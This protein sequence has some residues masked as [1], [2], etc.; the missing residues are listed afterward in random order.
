MLPL[1]AE[2][3]PKQTTCRVVRLVVTQLAPSS[4]EDGNAAEP[5]TL[6]DKRRV[7]ISFKARL[8]KDE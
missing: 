8:K 7:A 3:L 1:V 4:F 2:W 5:P 6:D